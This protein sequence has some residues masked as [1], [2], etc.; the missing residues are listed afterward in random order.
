MTISTDPQKVLMREMFKPKPKKTLPSVPPVQ[1]IPSMVESPVAPPTKGENLTGWDGIVDLV[2]YES[3]DSSYET[4]EDDELLTKNE[5]TSI[6]HTTQLEHPEVSRVPSKVPVDGGVD[7][8]DLDSGEAATSNR[9]LDACNGRKR[10]LTDTSLPDNINLRNKLLVR[11]P[12]LKRQKL[13]IPYRKQRQ[14]NK[15]ERLK[16]MVDAWKAV[17]K[18]LHSKK[19]K[20]ESGQRGLQQR[21][22][23]AIEC[24]LRLVIRNGRTS[25]GASKISAE[26]HFLSVKHGSRQLRAWTRRWVAQRVLPTS[27]RGMHTKMYS[28]FNDPQIIT[29]LRA[30]LRSNKWAMN[31][32]KLSQFTQQKLVPSVADAYLRHIIKDEMP[33]GLKRYMEVVLFPRIHLKVGRGVSISTARRWM[34]REGFRFL[35]YKKGLYYDGHDRDDVVDYRQKSFLPE[36]ERHKRRLVQY[37]VGSVEHEHLYQPDNYV[38]RRLVL[39]AHDEMTAQ[40]H[41]GKAKSWVLDDQHALRKK[42]VGRGIHQS[43]IICSTVGWLPEASQTLEYG[44]NYEGY[45]TGEL[46]IKQV[47]TCII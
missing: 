18:L 1:S 20:F 4:D 3:D 33:K 15:D 6:N 19:T 36:M 12:E 32:E 10:L 45:W 23:R 13:D 37:I 25:I 24:Q 40:A 44:K 43:D 17:Q 42:G 34:R 11:V 35:S 28:L 46:F 27:K 26:A 41:D 9:D 2:T 38:E 21:R 29:E 39:C 47:C 22:A 30:F 16:Q 14:L 7:D 31:P 5:G 8:I